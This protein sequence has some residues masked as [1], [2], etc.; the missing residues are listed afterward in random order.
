MLALR[1]HDER[2]HAN[3]GWLDSYHT[4]SFA[5]YVDRHQ[6]NFRALRVVNED[7]I[8]PGGGFGMHGHEDMEII[9]L[10]LAGSLAHR[11]SMGHGE[12]LRPGELQRMTAGTGI[13]HSEVNPSKTDEVH[14]YQ[15]W[16][17]P[18]QNGLPPSYEQR[19]LAPAGRR[20]RLQLA[21]SPDGRDG[22]LTLQQDAC[23]YLADLA[24]GDAVTH[25]LARG[26]HAW[27]QVLRGALTVNDTPVVAGDG[28][29]LSRVVA[30][31]LAAAAPAEVLL[32][33]LA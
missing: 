14:L 8:Q 24:P 6:M 19:A 18:R 12:L 1:R 2:G 26:R 20:G 33:D 5:D 13:Q 22:S 15:I 11:D 31:K 29:A 16:L 17:E 10:V 27:V 28:V 9:T 30:V 3:H 25:A 7:R 23:L 21:V 32:F 4:F